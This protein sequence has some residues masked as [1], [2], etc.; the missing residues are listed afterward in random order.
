MDRLR[1][2]NKKV[3]KI[4][5]FQGLIYEPKN[6]FIYSTKRNVVYSTKRNV[7]YP[8]FFRII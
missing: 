7:A 8:Q 2:A 5:L 6:G 4:Y 1:A 3:S